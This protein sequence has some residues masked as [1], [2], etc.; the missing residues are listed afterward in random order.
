MAGSKS[1]VARNRG[2]TVHA[3]FDFTYYDGLLSFAQGCYSGQG[4]VVWM[5]Q[6]LPEV[7][8]SRV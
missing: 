6:P 4:P 2:V 7:E 3:W 8:A 5:G 1:S